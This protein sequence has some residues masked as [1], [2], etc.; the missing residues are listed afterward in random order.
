M[1][2]LKVPYFSQLDNSNNPYGSCNVTS[3]AMCLHY[4]G[5]RGN[6]QGQ[7]EDQL[8]RKCE[9]NGWDRHSPTDLKKLAE[10]YGVKD[11]F[12][13]KA[14]LKDI[15][16]ALD[17]GRPCIVHGY[18]TESGHIIVIRGYDVTGFW[19]NDPYG[20][21]FSSGYRTDL[22]GGNLRYSYKLIQETCAVDGYIWLH[23]LYK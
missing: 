22:S 18:F 20:E 9:A 14:Y 5:I 13:A 21:Y 11:D 23:R 17:K 8:Y 10:S 4:L 1:V 2:N 7:L 15:K 12:S 19:V 6:G 16:E 3:I